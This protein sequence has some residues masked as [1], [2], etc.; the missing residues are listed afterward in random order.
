MVVVWFSVKDIYKFIF[1]LDNQFEIVVCKGSLLQTDHFQNEIYA[2]SSLIFQTSIK[3]TASIFKYFKQ[4]MQK[5]TYCIYF[6]HIRERKNYIE[7]NEKFVLLYLGV[8]IGQVR[9][10]KA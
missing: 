3:L 8:W 9:L 6:T 10:C 2:N 7:L 1:C 4:R 5:M